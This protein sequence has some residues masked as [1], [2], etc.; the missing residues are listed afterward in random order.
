MV[1]PLSGS[2]AKN[3]H[4]PQSDSD[5]IHAHFGWIR[6]FSPLSLTRRHRFLIRLRQPMDL[7]LKSLLWLPSLEEATIRRLTFIPTVLILEERVSLDN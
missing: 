2:S 5:A 1:N 6:L 7:E 3:F 4:Y